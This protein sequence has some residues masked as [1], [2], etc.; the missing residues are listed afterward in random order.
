MLILFDIDA[1][2]L[3]TSRA[4]LISM[5][6]AGRELFGE[7]FTEHG[8]D[9]AGRLDPLILMEL[10]ARNGQAFSPEL[11]LRFRETY[12]RRIEHRLR[13]HATS[14]AL[15]GVMD[16]LGALESVPGVTMGLLTGNF[17][18]SGAHKLRAAGIDP[19]RF[20]VCAWGDDS[21][22]D[23]PSRDHLPPVAMQRYEERFGSTIAPDRVTIIGDTPH[24]VRCAKAHGC[25]VLGVG[26][27]IFT[28]EQLLA[29]GADSAVET[30]E[31]TRGV[32]RWL[33]EPMRQAAAV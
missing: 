9:F 19:E 6:E 22:H 15:P 21:P 13:T 27:G 28:A 2:L 1:T 18:E 33:I 24:D 10:I 7:T 4:G 26:T 14:L 11:A 25:R 31:D 5:G 23:P 12:V 32:V 29:E 16:L 3:S 20:H 30:L 17:P 8:V